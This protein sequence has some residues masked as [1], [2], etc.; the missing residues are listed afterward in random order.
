[1]LTTLHT[2]R[3]RLAPLAPADQALYVAL[4]SDRETM[5]EIGAPLSTEAALRSFATAL[6][7]NQQA[8]AVR[9]TWTVAKRCDER[10][11]GVL[12]LV[13]V[14]PLRPLACAEVGAIIE[15]QAWGQRCT[16]EGLVRLMDHAFA[17]L[18]FETLGGRHRASQLAS[19]DLMAKIGF[20]R[21]PDADDP[22]PIRWLL[23][24][25]EWAAHPVWNPLQCP[26][27]ALR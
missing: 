22:L 21:Q 12:A 2:A 20:A 14:D 15:R 25:S 24:R 17:E 3:L 5:S 19:L 8:A 16:S 11:C 26:V 23:R 13:A 9:R 27:E 18:G 1:M 4:H 7:C 6:L 10:P